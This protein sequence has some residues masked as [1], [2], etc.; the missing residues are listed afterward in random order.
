MEWIRSIR[1][2]CQTAGVAFFL[3]QMVVNGKLDHEPKLDGRTWREFPEVR[4]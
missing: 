1:D 4:P 3:K 2:Q